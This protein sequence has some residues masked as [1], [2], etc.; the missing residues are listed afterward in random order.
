[1]ALIPSAYALLVIVAFALTLIHGSGGKPP[2]WVPVLL[3][4]IAMMIGLAR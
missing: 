4:C 3:L 1:V 2:L